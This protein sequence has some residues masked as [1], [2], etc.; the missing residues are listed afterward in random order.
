MKIINSVVTMVHIF[1]QLSF[2]LVLEC[3]ASQSIESSHARGAE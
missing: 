3:V 2:V 1:L